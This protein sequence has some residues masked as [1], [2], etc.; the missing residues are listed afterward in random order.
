MDVA[1]GSQIRLCGIAYNGDS[2]GA[3]ISIG[4]YHFRCSSIATNPIEAISICYFSG[5]I[6][7]DDYIC[8]DSTANINAKLD[9]CSY[10]IVAF[11]D[12]VGSG[13]TKFSY[14]LNIKT[15]TDEA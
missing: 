6:N 2:P 13:N 12:R 14:T 8:F 10:L 4:V 9:R 15:Q 3:P 7:S 1:A 11:N 5:S